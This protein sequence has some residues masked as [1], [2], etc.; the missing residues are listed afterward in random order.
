M[1]KTPIQS[2]PGGGW[3]RGS[4]LFGGLVLLNAFLISPYISWYDSGEMV[5]TTVCLGISHPSGQVLFHLL[6]KLFLLLP[7]GTPAYR[8]G[9]LSTVCSA[10]ASVLFWV[11]SCR[12]ARQVAGTSDSRISPML[13]TWLALLAAAWS[14][15]QPWWRYSL[16]PLVYALHLLLGL[17]LLWALSLDKPGKWLLAFFILGIATVFRPTQ[18]FALPF[19][20][21]GFIWEGVRY[22]KLSVKTFLLLAPFFGLGQSTALYLPLRSALRPAIAYA[23]L[24][25]P[26]VFIRHVLAMKFSQYVGTV[27]ASTILETSRQMGSHLWNDLTPLGVALLLWGAGFVYGKRRGIP[28]FFWVALGWGIVEALF[29]F[30]IPFPTFESHQVLLGWAYSGLLAVFP[31]AWVEM[32]FKKSSLRPI[33]VSVLLTAFLLAQFSQV[34]HFWERKKER[35][36]EDYARNLLRIMNPHALYVPAEENEYFPVVGYQ[37]SFGFREDVGVIEPGANPS[38]VGAEIRDGLKQ[39]RPLYVTRQWVL[40]PEWSYRD[41]G[42]LMAVVPNGSKRVL[43]K[44]L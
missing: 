7:F 22:R 14:L 44:R 40:P 43:K 41:W 33:F 9:F 38:S 24:T 6:G 28:L 8:L 29:V 4:A 1:K 5:G 12:L 42:P 23:D 18:F 34:G 3:A 27:S 26:M 39:D 10:L 20:G 30:T 2:H 35:G 19:V 21:L 11:L 31:L 36:A 32:F 16:T 37:Q 25:H 13:K 15:S 17:L